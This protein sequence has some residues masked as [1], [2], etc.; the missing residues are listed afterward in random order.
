LI[1]DGPLVALACVGLRPIAIG[2]LRD[3]RLDRQIQWRQVL[4]IALAVS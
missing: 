1:I 2:A 3:L 4:A